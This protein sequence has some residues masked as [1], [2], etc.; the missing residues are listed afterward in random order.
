MDLR[1]QRGAISG[2]EGCM[3]LAMLLFAVLLIGVLAVAFFRFQEPPT[4]PSMP[5]TGYQ[6]PVA[7]PA[8][9]AAGDWQLETAIA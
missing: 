2:A 8:R 7:S 6:S 9:L 3:F 5:A 4:G 1:N